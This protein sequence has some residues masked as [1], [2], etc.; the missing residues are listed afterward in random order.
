MSPTIYDNVPRTSRLFREEI[1]GPVLTVTT[2]DSDEEALELANDTEYGLASS[3]YTTDL[4]KANR[5]ARA[6]KA[7]VVSINCYSEGDIT[8]PFGGFK[9]S[10][11]LGRDK[12]I[13]AHLQYTEM[14]TVWMQN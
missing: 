5:Y 8:T 14:K 12:S 11:F 6:I 4:S 2:F 13:H 3:L 7:G 10:G 1:F 9:Q